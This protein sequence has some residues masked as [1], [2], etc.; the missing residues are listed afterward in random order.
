M[1]QRFYAVLIVAVAALFFIWNSLFVVNER[2]QAVVLRFGQIQRV[3]TEPGLYVKL[4][5]T[6]ANADSVQMLPDRLLRSDIIDLEVQVSGGAR[7]VVDAFMVYRIE[8]ARKFRNGV[9]GGSLEVAEQRLLT[10]FNSAIRATYGQRSFDAALSAA[11]AEMMVEIRDQVRPEAAALGISLEDIRISRTD[12][13][14]EVSEN[15]YSRMAAERLTEAERLRAEGQVQARQI[16]ATTE[17][18]ASEL[19]AG[20]RRD[21]AVLQ[22]EGQALRNATLAGVYGRNQEFFE[23]YRSM[24][25]YQNALGTDGPSMVL[26]PNSDF[27]RYFKNDGIGGATSSVAGT[28]PAAPVQGA[29][30]AATPAPAA[31]D[32]A[33]AAPNAAPAAAEPAPAGTP[34]DAPAEAPAATPTPTQ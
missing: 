4:P 3:V 24:Q 27:F 31:P 16:R 28:A 9:Q 19:V 20:A 13:T 32:A 8:D 2:E 5:F 15:T 10:R 30:E 17:R 21:A 6:F 25:A 33:P 26:S 14:S 34:A 29:G 18:E 23:F 22:G 11:R 12:L 7:Y 1:S